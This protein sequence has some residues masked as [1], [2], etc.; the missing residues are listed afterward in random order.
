LKA[1]QQ[2]LSFDEQEHCPAD[3][4]A[5]ISEISRFKAAMDQFLLGKSLLKAFCTVMFFFFDFL[6]FNS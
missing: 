4:A 3:P 1:D 5:L 2:F 6:K